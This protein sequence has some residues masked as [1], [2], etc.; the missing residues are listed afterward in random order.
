MDFKGEVGVVLVRPPQHPEPFT[1]AAVEAA[2]RLQL[3]SP[4]EASRLTEA[5]G[6]AG[7]RPPS[8]VLVVRVYSAVRVGPARPARRA[9]TEPNQ[10]V[11][12]GPAAPQ[13]AQEAPVKSV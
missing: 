3:Q 8:L 11:V 6:V 7:A 2:A 9:E 4:L 13:A 5:A 12:V 10:A 1:E